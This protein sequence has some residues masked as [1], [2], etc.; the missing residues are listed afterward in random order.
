MPLSPSQ[1][2]ELLDRLGHQPNKRLGQNFLI[3]GNIV[4]KSIDLA[5]LKEGETVVEIGPGLG[6]LSK[7]ILGRG[8]ALWAVERDAAL[9]A[10]L[11]E[12]IVPTF[13]EFHLTQ[14]DCLD[15]P[16]ADL[17]AANA[18]YFKIVANL[19]YAIS[20][21]WMEAVLNGPLPECMVLMLQKEAA[22]RYAATHGTKNFGAISIFLQSTFII[23]A[24]HHVSA[25]CFCPVPKVDSTLLWLERKPDGQTFSQ[26]AR[27]C[28]RRI[29]TQR[30]KQLGALCRKDAAP[31]AG[32]WFNQLV[33]QGVSAKARPEEVPLEHWQALAKAMSLTQ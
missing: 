16:L 8:C 20:T 21:P 5:G 4:R 32:V 26:S 19:P 29:F 10:H 15:Y 14:G 18:E 25:A 6:T 22:E 31:E 28:V 2:T 11:R 3:D 1:T 7:A 23:K 24:R 12:T 9:A 27:E 33:E 30:R 17:P 13:P